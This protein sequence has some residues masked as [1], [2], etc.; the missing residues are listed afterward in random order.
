MMVLQS[1]APSS[2][3]PAENDPKPSTATPALT[4]TGEKLQPKW[5]EQF[6]AGQ[7]PYK[8]RT[9]IIG[10]MPGF[11]PWA[12]GIAEGLS[13]EHGFPIEVAEVKPD[14]AK[15]K[16]GERLIGENGGF[17]CVQCHSIGP[18]GAITCRKSRWEKA[19]SPAVQT[20]EPKR[21]RARRLT[22]APPSGNRDRAP[23]RCATRRACGGGG[24]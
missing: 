1:G 5:M 9:W 7:V 20:S 6:I 21:M 16:F 18:R 14:V 17:N 19:S 15:A 24:R 2:D 11:V 22:A 3:A 13:L 23:F 4:W 12:K 10:R 8:P